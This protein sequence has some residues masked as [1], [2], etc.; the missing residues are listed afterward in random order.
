MDPSLFKNKQYNLGIR[1]PVYERL[2][3]YI[4]NR[5]K[6]GSRRKE[7]YN[8]KQMH[9]EFLRDSPRYFLFLALVNELP[10]LQQNC[11]MTLFAVDAALCG[12]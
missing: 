7:I 3:F 2:P 10:N 6:Y 5:A 8:L 11:N 4:Q 9:V 12:K 1:G